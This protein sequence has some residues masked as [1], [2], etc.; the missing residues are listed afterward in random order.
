M[1]RTPQTK[2]GWLAAFFVDWWRG[3]FNNIDESDT[4]SSRPK[5]PSAIVAAA[6]SCVGIHETGGN[7]KGPEL[8]KFFDSDWYDPNGDKPGDDGY[9]W[10]AAFVCWCVQEAMRQTGV[11][12]TATFKAPR[13]PG[14]WDFERWSLS[15]DESTWTRKP[16]KND[17]KAGD[18]VIFTFSHIGIAVSDARGNY[19]TTIEGNTNGVGS[20]EGDGVYEK[21]RMLS[22]IRSRI[23]F[24]V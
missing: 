11:K 6:K 24:R 17:I 22:Q 18:I 15:Q 9:A 1:A 16:H 19:V 10:C 14:A 21:T 3:G 5:L 4:M 8:Q 7:N 12:E 13:T 23:R 2:L 20:R